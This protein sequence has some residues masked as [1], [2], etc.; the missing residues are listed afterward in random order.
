M[1]ELIPSNPVRKTRFPRS[2]LTKQRAEIA[3]EKIQELLG[4]LPEPSQSVAWLLVLTGLRIGELLALRWRN[5]DL[6]KKELKVTHSVYDG[7]FDVP[8][9][10]RSQRSVAL[11]PKAVEILTARKPSA[12]NPDALVF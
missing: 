3:P 5:I 2:G 12:A 10:P 9:T 1:A 7:H 11:G 8:K 4:V 6:E